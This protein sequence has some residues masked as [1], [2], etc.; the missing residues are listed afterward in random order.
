MVNL[1]PWNTDW[2]LARR[3]TG[4]SHIYTDQLDCAP[5]VWH[6][7]Y[8]TNPLDPSSFAIPCDFVAPDYDQF[9]FTT[10]DCSKWM[11]MDTVAFS[12]EFQNFYQ[13]LLA[14]ISTR[15]IDRPFAQRPTARFTITTGTER[16]PVIASHLNANP[17]CVSMKHEENDL[18]LPAISYEDYDDSNPHHAALYLGNSATANNNFDT[19]GGLNVFVR[20]GTGTG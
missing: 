11:I 6:G 20:I 12:Y 15:F 16:L 9:L 14:S 1:G 17:H 4:N 2:K 5:T 8:S 13:F 18:A 7:T 10:G 19:L 3:T